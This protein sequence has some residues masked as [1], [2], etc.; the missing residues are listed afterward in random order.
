MLIPFG[1]V[2]G[3]AFFFVFC[4]WRR[5]RQ[6]CGLDAG[7]AIRALIRFPELFNRWRGEPTEAPRSRR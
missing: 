7:G 3:T 6:L 4:I 1:I 5:A 2:L